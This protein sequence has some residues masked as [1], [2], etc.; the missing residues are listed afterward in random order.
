MHNHSG[1]FEPKKAIIVTVLFALFL[2]AAFYIFKDK[3]SRKEEPRPAAQSQLSTKQTAD[4]P[5]PAAQSQL[6]TKQTAEAAF[7]NLDPELQRKDQ[8]INI[9]PSSGFI[10]TSLI[11][12][13]DKT[14]AVYAEISDCIKALNSYNASDNGQCQNWK[15]NIVVKN[16]KTGDANKIYSYP[17]QSSW[18][19]R[20]L[21]NRALAGGCTLID[22]PLA[23]SKNDKKIITKL[24]NPTSCGS[25][26]YTQYSFHTINPTGGALE[27]LAYDGAVFADSYSKVIYTDYDLNSYVCGSM[28]ANVG[29]YIILKEI[30]SGKSEKLLNQE[31]IDYSVVSL[32]PNETELSYTAKPIKKTTDGCYEYTNPNEN[33]ILNLK[34]N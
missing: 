5:R 27:D 9:T 4:E 31:G 15:Y 24:G 23:W 8:G 25:G 12:S 30:E 18:Y 33:K 32:N 3:N 13:H 7:V 11:L 10:V 19:Q 22:F 17:K 34:I 2:I 1:K 28:G 16:L 29:R 20:L 26:G 14:R 21:V 6:S